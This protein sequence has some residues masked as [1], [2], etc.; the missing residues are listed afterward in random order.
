MTQSSTG[1]LNPV[2]SVSVIR[3]SSKTFQLTVTDQDGNVVNLTGATIYFTVK[4][5]IKDVEW[6]IQK[7]STDVTQINITQPI[8]G[9][10]QIYLQPG[11]T[12]NL[13]PKDYIFDVWVVLSS[14]QQYP[15]VTPTTFEVEAGVTVLR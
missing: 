15:V 10:A 11:D 8:D 3:G 13:D 4:R 7:K 5:N 6:V 1:F 14:G 12:V 9:I 2:N